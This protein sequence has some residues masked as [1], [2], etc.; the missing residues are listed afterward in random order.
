MGMRVVAG[1]LLVTIII[2][3]SLAVKFTGVEIKLGK[4]DCT[5]DFTVVPKEPCTAKAKCDKKC[6]G[7][8]VV[9]VDV[10]ELEMQCKKGKCA[11]SSC[12]EGGAATTGSEPMPPTGSGSGATPLPITGSGSG[13][14]PLPITGSGSGE[15]PVPITGTGSGS[16]M[17]PMP[18]TGESM[19]CSCQCSCPEGGA[20]CDC[21][22]N[23]PVRSPMIYCGSGF[24]KV[25][26]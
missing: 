25:C 16:G 4:R 13:A 10:Y 24:T 9:V 23:C 8:G 5:C 12:Q 22:C 3:L 6:S 17:P 1:L 18:P 21:N 20:A 14:T 15:E 19:P 2:D 26:P 7:K 11:V